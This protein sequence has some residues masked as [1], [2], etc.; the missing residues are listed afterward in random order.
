MN[1]VAI[2]TAQP[3]D[4]IDGVAHL[5]FNLPRFGVSLVTLSAATDGGA[6]S[7]SGGAATANGARPGCACGV[8]DRSAS[9]SLGFLG[10]ALGVIRRR[11]RPVS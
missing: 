6:A 2:Q 7:A 4:A 10:V 8:A 5:T 3:M 1:P 11:R 9:W